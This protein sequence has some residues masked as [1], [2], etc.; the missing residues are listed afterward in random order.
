MVSIVHMIGIV[1]VGSGC[2]QNEAP[3]TSS[4]SE[5]PALPKQARRTP[6]APQRTVRRTPQSMR[7]HFKSGVLIRD[8][9]IA[10]D[11]ALAQWNANWLVEHEPEPDNASWS[12]SVTDL[13][14]RARKIAEAPDLATAAAATAELAAVCGRCH[15]A[16]GVSP[17]FALSDVRVPASGVRP[18]M[19]EHQ[20]AA[21]QMWAGLVGANEDTWNKGVTGFAGA[22]LGQE[23]IFENASATQ[24]ITALA[25]DVH[26]IGAEGAKAQGWPE[27]ANVY[28]RLLATC[29]TC[30]VET[31]R[32]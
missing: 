16:N 22:P 8:A 28:G 21:E 27:R 10:G 26:T 11:L 23:E 12:P 29:A 31:S 25:A 3:S 24:H 13:R 15:Q 9:L 2:K 6:A 17:R 4:T 5:V 32:R 30:H 18:H 14:A 7:E 1:A 20:W 19:L